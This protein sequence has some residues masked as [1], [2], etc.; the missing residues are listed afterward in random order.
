MG[1][2]LEVNQRFALGPGETW[3]QV[4]KVIVDSLVLTL[5]EFKV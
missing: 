3:L 5:E 4:R 1:I 2:E